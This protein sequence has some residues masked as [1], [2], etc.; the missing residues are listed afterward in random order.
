[1][2]QQKDN[3]GVLFRNGKK[4]KPLQPDYTGNVT[5]QGIDYR[6]SAWLKQGS[7]QK[8]FSLAFVAKIASDKQES[9][10]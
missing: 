5:V 9:K 8:Y 3:S 4:I 10:P 1:M 7:K 6:L 2:S